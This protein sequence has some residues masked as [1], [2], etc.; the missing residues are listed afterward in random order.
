MTNKQKKLELKM[1]SLKRKHMK[2]EIETAK[3]QKV[4]LEQSVKIL[5]EN[6]ICEAIA[7]GASQTHAV[8]A[9]SFA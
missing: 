1:K 5:R 4:A 8:K 3:R 2:D 6:L 7:G 9:A